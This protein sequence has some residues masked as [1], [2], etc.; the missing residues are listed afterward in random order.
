MHA[1]TAIAAD[2]PGVAVAGDASGGWTHIRTP[3]T[4]ITGTAAVCRAHADLVPNLPALAPFR[5]DI[6][7]LPE[8]AADAVPLTGPRPVTE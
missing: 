4:S 2:R 6:P 3:L 7:T 5:P 8:P 1:A